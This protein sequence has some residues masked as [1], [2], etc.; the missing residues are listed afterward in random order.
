MLC[1]KFRNLQRAQPRL[2]KGGGSPEGAPKADFL[3]QFYQRAAARLLFMDVTPLL[4]SH[5]YASALPC[6]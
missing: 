3:R 6:Q 4:T 2:A 5:R 1:Q